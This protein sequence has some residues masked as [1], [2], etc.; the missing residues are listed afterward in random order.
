[1]RFL[2]DNRDRDNCNERNRDVVLET[3]SNVT[4]EISTDSNGAH[5][6]SDYILAV[7]TL[8]FLGLVQ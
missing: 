8:S 6:L 2:G 5:A 4:A 1:M 7:P 3:S